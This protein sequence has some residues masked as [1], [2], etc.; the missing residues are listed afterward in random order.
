MPQNISDAD[1][2]STGSLTPPP[3]VDPRLVKAAVKES[4]NR[5]ARLSGRQPVVQDEDDNGDND[6]E[7]E[8]D[9]AEK[10]FQNGMSG[11]EDLGSGDDDDDDDESE[12][13]YREEV[14]EDEDGD[15]E[16]D[17]EIDQ[18]ASGH[19]SDAEEMPPQRRRKKN[20]GAS[21]SDCLSRV[22]N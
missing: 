14:D 11:S 13:M 19:S 10:V 3:A 21:S 12:D 9:G 18:L 17:S 8:E 6:N 16:E 22:S 4:L 2:L 7:G 20:D 1:A 5:V 15:E